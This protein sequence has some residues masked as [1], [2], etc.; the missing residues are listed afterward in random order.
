METVLFSLH[1]LDRCLVFLVLSFL[2]TSFMTF[3]CQLFIQGR[4]IIYLPA[5]P[6]SALECLSMPR[7]RTSDVI[8]WGFAFRVLFSL[9]TINQTANGDC[10]THLCKINRCWWLEESWVELGSTD[11]QIKTLLFCQ[12]FCWVSQGPR[13]EVNY[14]SHFEFLEYHKRERCIFS[15]FLLPLLAKM[16]V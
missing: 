16:S 2:T 15:L 4:A 14:S 12:G 8:R 9:Y 5:V 7:F 3:L 6:P 10:G 1:L 13:R 11:L